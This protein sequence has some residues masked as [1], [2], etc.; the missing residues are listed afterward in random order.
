MIEKATGVT[1]SATV[2]KTPFLK[3]SWMGRSRWEQAQLL[4]ARLSPLCKS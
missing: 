2:K 1:D 3:L 4:P